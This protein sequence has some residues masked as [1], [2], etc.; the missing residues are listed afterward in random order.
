VRRRYC[1]ARTGDQRASSSWLPR[2]GSSGQAPRHTEKCSVCRLC[3]IWGQG[4]ALL[5]GLHRTWSRILSTFIVMRMWE[6]TCTTCPSG[7]RS[8][9]TAPLPAAATA[10]ARQECGGGTSRGTS[11]LQHWRREQGMHKQAACM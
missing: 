11:E 8:S 7:R 2:T 3:A 1:P 9:T 5:A 4:A 10:A 6:K